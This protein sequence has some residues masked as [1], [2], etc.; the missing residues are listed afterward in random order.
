MMLLRSRRQK[1]IEAIKTGEK[2]ITFRFT[3]KEE[4]RCIMNK[5]TSMI[6]EA[7]KVKEAAK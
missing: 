4:Y 6:L 1:V 7:D 2:E 5:L 3:T